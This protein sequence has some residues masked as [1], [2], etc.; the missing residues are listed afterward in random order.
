MAWHFRDPVDPAHALRRCNG[1][2]HLRRGGYC[3]IVVRRLHADG[4]RTYERVTKLWKCPIG[5]RKTDAGAV[6]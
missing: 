6:S 4:R 5:G 1:C 3:D 2:V